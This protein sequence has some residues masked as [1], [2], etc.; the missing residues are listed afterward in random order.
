M[1]DSMTREFSTNTEADTRDNGADNDTDNDSDSDTD[2]WLQV[3]PAPA[4]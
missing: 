2:T 3:I 1:L 4:C